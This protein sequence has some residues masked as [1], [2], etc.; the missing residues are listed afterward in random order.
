[1]SIVKI[2]IFTLT[3]LLVGC[4]GEGI[5]SNTNIQNKELL[6]ITDENIDK[7]VSISQNTLVSDSA[8]SAINGNF[9]A[10]KRVISLKRDDRITTQKCESGTISVDTDTNGVKTIYNSCKVADMV[11]DGELHYLKANSVYNFD[12]TLKDLKIVNEDG[13]F[14]YSSGYIEARDSSVHENLTGYAIING[15]R[16]D[17]NALNIDYTNSQ[18]EVKVR[19]DGY[20]THEDFDNKW[21]KITTV[22]NIK[23][24]SIQ[25]CPKLGLLDIEGNESNIEIDYKIDNVDI[26]F[27]RD[28]HKVYSTCL[29]IN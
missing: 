29:E 13:E 6:T 7:V 20:I 1:M 22:K 3:F 14:Y 12:A 16:V 2:A 21:L 28:L 8:L 23:K 18:T 27:N 4:G 10:K 26:Y 5:K 19:V 25:N 9:G 17:F 11:I 15:K 24:E